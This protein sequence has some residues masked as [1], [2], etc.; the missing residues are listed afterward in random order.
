MF[1]V[2]TSQQSEAISIEHIRIG[3]SSET[4]PRSAWINSS[5]LFLQKAK[6]KK[7]ICATKYLGKVAQTKKN[8]WGTKNSNQNLKHPETFLVENP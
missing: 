6:V 1:Q 8:V 2:V 5:V 7:V 3:Y 4:P